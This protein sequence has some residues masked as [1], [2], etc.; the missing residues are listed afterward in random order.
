MKLDTIGAHLIA[1]S[2][3][4]QKLLLHDVAV[5]VDFP[6]FCFFFAPISHNSAK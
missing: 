5:F 1:E 4:I 6:L 2:V 3:K